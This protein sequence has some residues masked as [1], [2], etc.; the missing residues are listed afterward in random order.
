MNLLESSRQLGGLR[1]VELACHSRLGVRSRRARAPRA[2]RWLS[3][4]GLAHAWRAM[5]LEGLLP[6]SVGLPRI[7][8]LTV[9]PEG[10][11][12]SELA[13][14]LPDPGCQDF[15][16][17]SDP[18]THDRQADDGNSFIDDLCSH[19][20]PSLLAAYGE[21]LETSSPAAD[22]AICRIVGRAVAD[23]EAVRAEGLALVD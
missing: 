3:S 2:V 7:D 22:G 17:A 13:R 10:V 18:R 1:A 19:L 5:L 23:L 16:P 21:R 15:D 4:A 14:V 11:L 9:L 6:V 20:Y 8:E 12:G